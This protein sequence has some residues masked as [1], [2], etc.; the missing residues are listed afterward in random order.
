MNEALS[1]SSSS[2]AM[3]A[4]GERI[5]SYTPW[6]HVLDVV[7]HPRPYLKVRDTVN[8]IIVGFSSEADYTTYIGIMRRTGGNSHA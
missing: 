2:S 6:L 7:E 4:L 8:G 3:Q 5:E 1:P